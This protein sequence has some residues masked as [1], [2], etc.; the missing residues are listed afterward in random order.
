HE[1]LLAEPGAAWQDSVGP[2]ASQPAPSGE[3]APSGGP[4]LGLRPGVRRPGDRRP[5]P[6]RRRGLGTAV[7]GAGAA[8]AE[9]GRTGRAASAVVGTADRLS[10]GCAVLGPARIAPGCPVLGP[11]RSAARPAGAPAPAARPLAAAAAVV[12]AAPL[13][14]RGPGERGDAG[15]GPTRALRTRSRPDGGPLR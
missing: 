2:E 7:D 11:A 6:E 14:P 8:A 15:M 9:L 4:V 13:R 10:P 3:P 1:T 5:R 12:V